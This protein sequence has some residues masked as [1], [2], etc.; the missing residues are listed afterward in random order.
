MPAAPRSRRRWE[1]T[2]ARAYGGSGALPTPQFQAFRLHTGRERIS[3]VQAPTH[4]HRPATVVIC[5]GHPGTLTQ[6][7]MPQ[8]L[9]KPLDVPHVLGSSLGGGAGAASIGRWWHRGGERGGAS[10]EPREQL[11]IG[12]ERRGSQKGAGRGLQHQGQEVSADRVSLT[13]TVLG[14]EPLRAET[15]WGRGGV[16]TGRGV[17]P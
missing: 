11:L 10:G 3:A 14:E 7:P 16:R 17:P 1:G 6:P 13:R 5:Y 9:R 8:Q 4:A 15:G 2:S 12:W